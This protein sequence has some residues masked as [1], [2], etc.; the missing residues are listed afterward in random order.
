MSAAFLC[1]CVL[2]QLQCCD[3]IVGSEDVYGELQ[4]SGHK[5]QDNH[6]A[7][8][9]EE[10]GTGENEAERG[11]ASGEGAVHMYRYGSTKQKG[12]RG[13]GTEYTVKPQKLQVIISNLEEEEEA[14]S[15]F[16]IIIRSL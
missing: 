15:S 4:R 7:G 12:Q 13:N 6:Y 3:M 11:G 9:S 8:S 16:G 14:Q 10:M 1:C 5:G 2:L